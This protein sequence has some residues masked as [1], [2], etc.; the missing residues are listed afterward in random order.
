MKPLK[1]YEVRR[2]NYLR[3]NNTNKDNSNKSLKL[4][5]K[6]AQNN[7]KN[8]NIHNKAIKIINNT[9]NNDILYFLIK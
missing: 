7:N 8:Y 3:K 1:V 6:P 5:F 9:K 2:N 4:R